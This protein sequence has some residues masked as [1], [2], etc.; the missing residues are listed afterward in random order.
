MLALYRFVP[1]HNFQPLEVTVGTRLLQVDLNTR[2]FRQMDPS[3]V[4]DRLSDPLE[5]WPCPFSSHGTM[6]VH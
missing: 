5:N 3:N 2:D 6:I 1:G 4:I